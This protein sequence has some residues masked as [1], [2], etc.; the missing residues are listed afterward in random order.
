[1]SGCNL[2]LF[3]FE[4]W[5]WVGFCV[6]GVRLRED[7]GGYYFGVVFVLW[8]QLCDILSLSVFFWHNCWYLYIRYLEK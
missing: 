3:G 6:E 8:E 4:V 2:E 1:M 7:C 5:L